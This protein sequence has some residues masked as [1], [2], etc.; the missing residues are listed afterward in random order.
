ME[1]YAKLALLMGEHPEHGI[2]RRFATLNAQNLLYLQAELTVLEEQH[3]ALALENE[4]SGHRERK[5]YATN[6]FMLNNSTTST[7]EE[8]EDRRQWAMF[9][10]IREKLSQY[11]EEDVM[12]SIRQEPG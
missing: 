11:S 7:T 3:L 1:G 4:A 9:L 12:D 2:F 5:A 8:G 6:W 10:K